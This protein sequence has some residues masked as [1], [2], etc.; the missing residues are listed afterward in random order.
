M[1]CEGLTQQREETMRRQEGGA[2][3]HDSGGMSACP[4]EGRWHLTS[5]FFVSRSVSRPSP[6]LLPPPPPHFFSSTLKLFNVDEN[7]PGLSR[8][9]RAHRYATMFPVNPHE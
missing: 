4:W 2:F 7:F 8:P 5:D 9:A 3:S 6:L 1:E